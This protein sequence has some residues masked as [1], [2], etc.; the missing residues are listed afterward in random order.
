MKCFMT[1]ADRFVRRGHDPVPLADKCLLTEL[2]KLLKGAGQSQVGMATSSGP[3]ASTHS[4]TTIVNL[5]S[6]LCRGSAAATH[7]S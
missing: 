5:L 2:M 1:L 3:P 6:T 4:I 7:V